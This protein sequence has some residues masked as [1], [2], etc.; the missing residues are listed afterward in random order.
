[1]IKSDLIILE[2]DRTI[3]ISKE[4]G[5]YI[6]H[7]LREEEFFSTKRNNV[8]IFYNIFLEKNFFSSLTP[9]ENKKEIVFEK[10]IKSGV[11]GN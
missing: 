5:V 3:K 1:M 7:E 8:K 10:I 11:N 4:K 9:K 2:P 6:N